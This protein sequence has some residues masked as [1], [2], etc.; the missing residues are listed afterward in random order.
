MQCKQVWLKYFRNLEQW[1]WLIKILQQ[2][3][4]LDFNGFLLVYSET[5]TKWCIFTNFIRLTLCLEVDI[6]NQYHYYN[7]VQ[8]VYFYYAIIFKSLIFTD[9]FVFG[10]AMTVISVALGRTFH[11][12][13]ELLPFRF[14]LYFL[15]LF[16]YVVWFGHTLTTE[17]VNMD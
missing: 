5:Y 11:Y 9:L 17:K 14:F 6:Y 12:V 1:N 7:F 16:I 2:T 4:S 3:I 13:D 15:H 10:R 8:C